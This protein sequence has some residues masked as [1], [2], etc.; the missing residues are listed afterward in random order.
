MSFVRSVV[1]VLLCC[2][3]GAPGFAQTPELTGSDHPFLGWLTA[4]YR[5]RPM[6]RVSFQ[7]SGRIDRIMRAG[8][9]Y[10]SL[11]DAIALALENNLDIEYARFNPRLQEANLLR[12][13]AGQLLRN[14]SNNISSGQQSAG[15][16]VLASTQLGSG[17]TQV[18]SAGGQGGVLSGLSV[19]LAG[20][21]I[22]NLDPVYFVQGQFVHNTT[23]ET[24]T[25]I[26]GTNFLVTQYNSAITGVQQGLLTGTT[27]QLYMVNQLGVT[28]NS[29]YNMFSPYNQSSLN[30]N[31]TQ[32]LLQGFRP[33]VNNRA[34][35]VAKDQLRIGDLTF[36]NQVMATVANVVGLYWDLVA[37]DDSLKVKQQ[38]LALETKLYQDNKR[39]AEL[40]AIAPFDVIQSEAEM[41]SAQQDVTTQQ[42]QVLQQETILK[43]VLTRSGLD[44]PDIVTAR[45]VPTDHFEVPAQ[46]PV[47]P[48]Q[49][50]I[51]QAM[52]SRPDVQQS[53][54]GLED[55][56][57]T[58]KGVRDALLPQLQAFVNLSNSGLA[59]QINAIPVPV[60]LPNGETQLVAR[61]PA[62]VNPFFLGGYGSVL[63]QLFSR[64]FP[65]YSVGI[66]LNIP[67]RNRAA[68]ADLITDQ[69]NYR[70]QQIQDKQLRNGIRQNVI[71]AAVAVTQAHSAYDTSVEARKL[72]EQTSAG[73]R[74]KYDLGTATILDVVLTQRD[75]TTRELAE[76]QARNAYAHARV[77]LESALGTVL[78]DYNVDIDQAKT[79]MVGREPDLIP[80]VPPGTVPKR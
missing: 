67:I 46:E 72:Q 63:N 60:Q 50:L 23:I 35:R 4:D 13:S 30:L 16:G 5:A 34:I 52:A 40:G 39:K 44:R 21:A 73:T 10:L 24:A 64:N 33:S 42:M 6:P 66:S 11:R 20:S 62:D 19:Q 18:T 17:G 8:I 28:Q 7:D 49:D 80:A 43:A 31:I 45:I 37:D 74:R 51:T 1:A 69:L 38:T 3:M 26:T 56:R 71:N 76:V 25:N 55:S 59:G 14:V 79:G 77:N 54:I 65:N 29:P 57:I 9:I 68:R 48:V 75:T 41:K 12:A 36:K 70:Q 47:Q 15:L 2:I 32:N 53:A 27:V 78:Q 22:P 61:T 58:T